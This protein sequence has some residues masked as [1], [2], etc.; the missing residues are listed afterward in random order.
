MIY[1]SQYRV[2]QTK[3]GYPFIPLIRNTETFDFTRPV[4]IICGGNGSGKTTFAK[5]ISQLANC[6]YVAYDMNG[7]EIFRKTEDCFSLTKKALSKRRFYFSAADFSQFVRDALEKKRD[8]LAAIE[9]I[10]ADKQMSKYAKALAEGPHYDVLSSM[11]NFYGTD[12]S[13][14]SHGQSFLAFFDKRLGDNGFYVIDEPEAA[15]TYENQYKLAYRIR[16]AALNR[17]CQ[18]IICTHSPVISAIPDAELY[19]IREDKFVPAAWEE[20]ENAAFLD[21]FFKRKDVLFH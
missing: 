3:S 18:F 10:V 13:E 7:E 12:L 5:I 6:V 11:E 21:M 19:E 4:T 8:A 15:L 16:D 9:E 14:V 20:T 2:K 1:V 17:G